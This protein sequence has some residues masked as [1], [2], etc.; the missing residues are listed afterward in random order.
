MTTKKTGRPGR[1]R[2]PNDPLDWVEGVDQ[3]SSEE[4]ATVTQPVADKQENVSAAA[5]QT[6]TLIERKQEKTMSETKH[7]E[8]SGRCE[9]IGEIRRVA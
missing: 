7:I 9:A 1:G 8:Q 4:I 2:V 3:T 6:Q 5:V